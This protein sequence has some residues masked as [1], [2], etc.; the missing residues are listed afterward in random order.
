M[1]LGCQ[2]QAAKKDPKLRFHRGQESRGGERWAHSAKLGW[3]IEPDVL[4]V[5]L[6][7]EAARHRAGLKLGRKG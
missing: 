5:T 2:W 4:A 7:R 3:A 1:S 6:G